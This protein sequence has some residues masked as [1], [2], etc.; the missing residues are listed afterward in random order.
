MHLSWLKLC[1][2]DQPQ[3]EGWQQQLDDKQQQQQ[4]CAHPRQQHAAL[5]GTPSSMRSHLLQ[6]FGQLQIKQPQH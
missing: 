3:Q 5:G 2:V 4:Q 6:Q 1:R